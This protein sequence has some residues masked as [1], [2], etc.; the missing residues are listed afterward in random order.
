MSDAEVL[1]LGVDM[2]MDCDYEDVDAVNITEGLIISVQ[3]GR[4]FGL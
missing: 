1:H 2:G 4:M 3:S